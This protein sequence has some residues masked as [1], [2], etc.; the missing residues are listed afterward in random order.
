[1]A[2]Q[3]WTTSTTT[4][5]P[6]MYRMWGGMPRQKC[7][8]NCSICRRGRNNVNYFCCL[9]ILFSLVD[10]LCVNRVVFRLGK[11]SFPKPEITSSKFALTTVSKILWQ[12]ARYMIM[13]VASF[14]CATSAGSFISSTFGK[15]GSSV[16]KRGRLGGTTAWYEKEFVLGCS[17]CAPSE[18]VGGNY[19][20]HVHDHLSSVR[21]SQKIWEALSVR[22]SVNH[23]LSANAPKK[24]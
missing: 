8:R 10:I 16:L 22:R 13:K 2:S 11:Y 23:S 17:P 5:A 21:D 18:T 9:C 24:E 20:W 12:W 6:K 4:F 1:M 3:T 7:T 14:S 19:L 15:G